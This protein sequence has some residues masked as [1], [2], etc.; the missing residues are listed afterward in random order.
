[1][2][3]K[4]KQRDIQRTNRI[5][6]DLLFEIY[7][8]A[9]T[10]L[11]VIG[12]A[13]LGAIGRNLTYLSRFLV[14]T[15]DFLLPIFGVC[16]GIYIMVKRAWPRHWSPKMSG[17]LIILLCS[18]G[19]VH[20]N[21][22]QL[23]QA[24]GFQGSVMDETW[25]LLLREY[26]SRLPTDIGGGMIGGF[27]YALFHFLF[28][29][30]GT[31]IVLSAFLL[32]GV[33][34]TFGISY[35]QILQRFHQ[36]M[37][38]QKAGLKQNVSKMIVK[39]QENKSKKRHTLNKDA[40]KSGRI[41]QNPLVE[42]EDSPAPT[43][44]DFEESQAKPTVSSMKSQKA[45]QL[46]LPLK[47]PNA[48][49]N[50]SMKSESNADLPEDVK[51]Q[52]QPKMVHYE[53][54][55]LQLLAKPKKRSGGE[56]PDLSKN[57]ELLERTLESFGV[58]ARVMHIHRGPS[59]TRYEIQPPVGVKVSRIVGLTDDLALALAAK[60]IRME[61]PIP[62]KSAIGIEV[63]NT[64]TS[65]VWLRDIIESQ[66][67]Q[68]SSNKLSI[69]LGK[70]ISGEP[71][72]AN[73][74]KMPHLLVAGATGAGKSVCINGIIVSLLY[75][76]KPDEVKLMMIDPKMVELNIYN[77]IPHLLVPVV[78]DARKAAIALKKVVAEM[79]KRYELF[80]KNGAR[81]MERYNQLAR[82]RNDEA[83]MPILPYIVVIVDELADLMMVAPGD[84]EDAICR[85][86]QMARAAGIH[87][88]IA[89]QRPSV[90]VITG[91][92]KANIPSRIAFTV[93]S[94][95]DSRTILDMGGAE[96]LLGRGD[97]LYMPIG[98]SKPIRVQGTFVSD[99]EVESVVH[100]VKNQQ[101]AH[102]NEE[103][104]PTTSEN[105][106]EDQVDDELYPQ[107]VNLVI[108]AK[109]ASVSLLQRRLRVGYTRA[110]RLIDLME[111]RGIVGPYEG[112]KPREVLV[113]KESLGET[114]NA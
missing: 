89:T 85:L 49:E 14:G 41:Y 42:D 1:M 67:Y 87:L 28:D 111:A 4:K 55:P 102:Y 97:M 56:R 76:S 13:S 21:T 18:L 98:A 19:F 22:F 90:D 15:W 33:L 100:F 78:T 64:E 5:K 45:E 59:V 16:L 109:T 94:Q 46:T 70:D 39:N 47:N 9:I 62:G 32:T 6:H 113:T 114:T 69:G 29:D 107:A 36:F 86:A 37:R 110:A 44:Y 35:V 79:E 106:K 34:L 26:S 88:I 53:L 58:Q 51:F 105:V 71:I 101:E 40:E 77:G 112:S 43:I 24:Q 30:V 73:L 72:V 27:V 3:K 17:I 63:P 103:M 104:I 50:A 95:A 66:T 93:S 31:V 82:E 23:L 65:M 84:V 20:F 61:A 57:A 60:D 25:N 7:G 54:P 99:E 91:V 38:Q 68:N 12:L 2:S 11:S 75:K 48:K 10:A 92:I 83:V 108:E 8:I 80:A 81:D 96:K 52:E 74:A